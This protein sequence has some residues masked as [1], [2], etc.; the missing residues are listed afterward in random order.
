MYNLAI[1]IGIA[2]VAF[3]AGWLGVGNWL[4]GFVPAM[5]ALSIAYVLLARRT[6]KQ[7]E[8]LMQDSMKEFQARRIEKGRKIL[9]SGFA[10]GR[11]QFLVDAQVHA[12][13]GTIDY[14]QGNF[15][16]AR[17]HLEKS[18]SRHWM[19][20]ALLATVDFREKK[21]EDALKRM[22]KLTGPGGKDPVF[23][24]LYAHMLLET[25]DR[26][27]ALAMLAK[28]LEKNAGSDALKAMADAVRNKRKVKMKAFA[29]AWYQ[30]FPEDMP[31]TMM[32]QGQQTRPGQYTP[33]MPR[34]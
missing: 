24:G 17:K 34:R 10:L 8:A 29:P 14:M 3:V 13:I 1:S 25:G 16:E 15:R 4:A 22:D 26:D 5:L 27:K 33:P 20:Q 31:R 2:V 6:G 11:W 30:F 7:L 32:M 9:E 28:G 12:Q 21:I 23:W 18:W 19:A